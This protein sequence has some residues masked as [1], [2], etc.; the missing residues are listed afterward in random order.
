VQQDEFA[1]PAGD[2][3]PDS[4]ERIR[5]FL[6]RHGGP[7]TLPRR[8]GTIASGVGGWYEVYAA[9]GYKL[10]CDWSRFGAREELKFSEIAPHAKDDAPGRRR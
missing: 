5:D 7:G 6:V 10:R 2:A 1:D 4:Q 3:S 8:D 9:D